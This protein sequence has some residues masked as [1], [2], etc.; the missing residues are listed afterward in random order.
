MIVKV[1]FIYIYIKD[2]FCWN[3]GCKFATT[4]LLVIGEFTYC[5]CCIVALQVLCMFGYL[6]NIFNITVDAAGWFFNEAS[7]LKRCFQA[8]SWAKLYGPDCCGPELESGD[9]TDSSRLALG[10]SERPV[11]LTTTILFG[12]DHIGLFLLSLSQTR[13]LFSV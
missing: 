10:D 6:L 2:F 3:V 12:W 9:K 4:V 5:V 8:E 11:N 1:I 7:D 13:P